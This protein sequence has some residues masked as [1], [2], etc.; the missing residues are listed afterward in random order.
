MSTSERLL[1]VLDLFTLES[2]D[3]SVEEAAK[4]TRVATSTTYLY[5]ANLTRQGLLAPCGAGRYVQV[6]VTAQ[7]CH[8]SQM[9]IGSSIRRLSQS[10][11][12][13]TDQMHDW[14]NPRAPDSRSRKSGNSR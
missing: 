13:L 2:P 7:N 8:I 3:W 14:K 12:R 9:A 1:A 5:F 11:S 10:A 4:A 6:I